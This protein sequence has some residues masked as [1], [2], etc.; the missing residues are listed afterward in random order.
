MIPDFFVGVY[1][2]DLPL[3]L[4]KRGG[5]LLDARIAHFLSLR[6]GG[7]LAAESRVQHHCYDSVQFIIAVVLK[8][9]WD[10]VATWATQPVF[11][12]LSGE[13]FYRCALSLG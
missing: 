2:K 6:R 1:I 5:L 3:L 9:D 12:E 4:Q 7:K 8:C 13:F 11:C 10:V